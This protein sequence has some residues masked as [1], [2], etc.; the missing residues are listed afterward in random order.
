[1]AN[2]TRNA[3][4]RALIEGVLTDLMVKTNVDN[5]YINDTTTLAAKLSEIVI[6][7]NNK[8][9][10]DTVNAAIEALRQEMLGDTP[11]AAYNTFTELAN[12][13]ESHEDVS[14][15]LSTAIGNK[16]DKGTVEALVA[17]VNG[18]GALA[19]KSVVS[20]SD[21]DSNLRAKVNTASQG[22]HSHSNKSV[23][24]GITSAKVNAWD[25]KARVIVN[26][27][28]PSDLTVNDLWI[29]PV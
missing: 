14:E 29:Q 22:N 8:A 5:V 23:L 17:T 12:Y 6:S 13:I 4:L 21:L 1:M 10:P 28:Q 20:E 15:A 9:T 26:G 16:A 7:L 27:S 3:I 18:L 2:A 11:V 24:D 19:K 25:K